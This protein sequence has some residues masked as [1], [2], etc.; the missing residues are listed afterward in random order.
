MPIR[1]VAAAYT[2]KL[3][4]QSFLREEAGVDHYVALAIGVAISGAIGYAIYQWGTPFITG[5][6]NAQGS[7]ITSGIT[8]P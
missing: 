5:Y 2:L 6:L 8:V 4:T 3:R 1:W 7:N